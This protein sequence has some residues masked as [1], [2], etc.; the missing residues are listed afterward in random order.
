[1]DKV[2]IVDVLIKKPAPPTSTAT[3]GLQQHCRLEIVSPLKRV[4]VWC[5]REGIVWGF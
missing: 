5:S 3:L 4:I 2:I 1:M